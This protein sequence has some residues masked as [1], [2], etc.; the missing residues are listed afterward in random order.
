[1][2]SVL[3]TVITILFVLWLIAV[4][5]SLAGLFTHLILLVV[6]VTMVYHLLTKG[7]AS[8]NAPTLST[9]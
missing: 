9:P 3:W 6:L 2:N 8:G 1:M 7:I 5:M 4:S